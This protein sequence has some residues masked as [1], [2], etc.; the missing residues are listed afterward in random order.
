M[1]GGMYMRKQDKEKLLKGILALLDESDDNDT[2]QDQQ[3]EQEDSQHPAEQEYTTL[4]LPLDL[5]EENPRTIVLNAEVTA[6]TASVIATSI[7]LINKEDKDIPVE[8]REPIVVWIDSP[9]GSVTS[10]M[11]VCN[12][13]EESETETIGVVCG[14]AAS[15][16]C[17]LSMAFHKTYAFKD[18]IFLLHDG[19]FSVDNSTA[20]F[21][22]VIKLYYMLKEKTKNFVTSHTNITP[23]YYEE[24]YRKELYLSAQEARE[25]GIIDGIIGEDIKLSEIL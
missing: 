20:K 8:E 4:E 6:K 2:Q 3:E 10:G 7:A 5:Q 23:K 21:E 9:G 16:A 19:E 18:S 11:G 25:L 1:N 15:M 13:L 22:D 17:L 14:N 24:I 12:I